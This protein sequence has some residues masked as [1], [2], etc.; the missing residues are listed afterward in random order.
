MKNK[1][2]RQEGEASPSRT[3]AAGVVAFNPDYSP[4]VRDLKR[5]GMLAS[6]FIVVLIAL[7]FAMPYIMP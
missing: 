3:T 5:I 6:F 1:Y 7:A 2:K 4:I